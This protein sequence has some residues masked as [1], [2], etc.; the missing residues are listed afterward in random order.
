MTNWSWTPLH[1]AAHNGHPK[2]VEELLKFG[3]NVNAISDQ[4]TTPLDMAASGGENCIQQQIRK[5]LLDAGG[6][7]ATQVLAEKRGLP[8][9]YNDHRDNIDL[10]AEV[11]KLLVLTRVFERGENASDLSIKQRRRVF[12]AV[13]RVLD[14]SESDDDDSN[15]LS[16]EVKNKAQELRHRAQ[17]RLKE[18]HLHP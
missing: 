5:I 12:R 10:T 17:A 2:C 18:E 11:A 9:D 13:S 15:G 3:A 4:S 6:K 16:E 14:D 1:W 7:T 8:S